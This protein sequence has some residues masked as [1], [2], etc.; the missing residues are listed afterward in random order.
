MILS[1]STLIIGS[2]AAMPVSLVNFS[3]LWSL[4]AIR[5]RGASDELANVGK[6]ALDRRGGDHLRAHQMS[7]AAGALAALEVAV[8]RRGGA[9][10]RTQL[11]GIHGEA[12]RASRLA[13]LE[14]RVGED[15]VEAFLFR[16]LLDQT[17]A[18]HDQRANAVRDLA[19]LGD[20]G[21]G[22]QVLD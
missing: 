16:L 14:S 21:G 11:V 15:A 1:V 10:S 9:L 4:S 2:G 6:V 3:I 8:R 7:A 19:A 5:A 13:P 22:A 17:G 12:H 20:G 18:R